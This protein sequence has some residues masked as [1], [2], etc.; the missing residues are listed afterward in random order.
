[1]SEHEKVR[2]RFAPSPTGYLHIGGARTALFNWL[3]AKSCGGIFILRIEDTDRDRSTDEYIQAILAGMQWLGL[4]A[5]EGPYRQTDRLGV[6]KQ[7]IDRILAEEK[8]YYC[9][10][11]KEE[12]EVKKAAAVAAK[13]LYKYDGTC[14]QRKKPREG[15]DPVV[16][17]KMPPGTTVVDDLIRGRMVFENSQLDDFIIARSDGTP[18][19]NF[20][21]VI[22]DLDMNIS[23]IIRGDDHINNT[24]KQIQ[25]YRALSL[26]EPPKF[27]HL[28][29][30]LGADKARLSK[31]HG[32]TSVMAYKEMGYLPEA[33]NN[34]LVRL[35]WSSGDQ[36]VFSMQEM[37]EKFSFKSIGKAAAVF[38]PEKLLW[39][40]AHY[41]KSMSSEKL[42]EL[43]KP[44]LS[45]NG[46]ISEDTVLDSKWLARAVD[47]LKERSRT[48]VEMADSM[49]YYIADEVEYDKKAREKFLVDESL[50]LLETLT[51]HIENLNDFTHDTLEAV[52]K[53]ICEKAEIKLKKLAQ[54]VRVALTGGTASPGIYELIEV[55]GKEKTLKRLKK[56][57]MVINNYRRKLA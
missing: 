51:E 42:S 13:K 11:T 47:T 27:A 48:L 17:F 31:R 5:D 44:F 33:L 36:E 35:G 18:V 19:Y 40:N 34:Y 3:Y 53:E 15:V 23:H 2:V 16:R 43:L 25:L 52:F 9:Y 7:Y 50:P 12:L 32:A 49:R 46:L 8:A 6:Y 30:I 39:L 38:N 22:D 57:I 45:K 1:M 26:K 54:P 56:A 4:K 14:R 28:P 10:C 24:P 37:I 55:M 29:M 21:V 20:V 41:I